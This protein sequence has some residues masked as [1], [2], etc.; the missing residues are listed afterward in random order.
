MMLV[1][2]VVAVAVVPKVVTAMVMV[3]AVVGSSDRVW[4][5]CNVIKCDD[6]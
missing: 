4:C 5:Q 6:V 1:L 2:V 3:T